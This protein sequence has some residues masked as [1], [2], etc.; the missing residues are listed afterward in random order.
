MTIHLPGS[1]WIGVLGGGQLGRML[2]LEARRMGY[3]IIAWTGG[4]DAGP[5]SMADRVLDAPFDCPDAL[6]AFLDRATVAT[7]EFENI[8]GDLLARIEARIPLTPSSSAV[9]ICQHRE[10]EKAFLSQNGFP[11]VWHSLVSDAASLA[12]AL[13]ALPGEHGILKT[14]EF[15]YDGKGQLPVSRLDAAAPLWERFG[16]TRAVLEERIDLAAELSVLVVRNRR[17]Q[18]LCYEPA[19]NA[20]RHHILDW[21]L[22]PSGL[23]DGLVNQA[24]AVAR[25]IVN[26]LDFQGVLAVEFFLSRDGRLLVNELAPRPHNSGHHTLDACETSQFEQQLRALCNLPAGGTRTLC[27]VVMV[28]LLGDLWGPNG[29]SPD[30]E[31]ILATP[32]AHLHLYGKPQAR[33]GRKMGHATFLAPTRDEA[34]ARANECRERLGLPAIRP[35]PS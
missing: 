34:I 18:T 5:A 22:I 1:T 19:W 10:R 27:P 11:C 6:A 32:G 17:G 3:Q 2:A 14:A 31:P 25:E 16:S 23:P 28:N 12:Q 4:G 21:S 26:A 15:G 13:A 30:W 33:P 9:V 29:E 35:I 7:V 20:H 24:Q 8:P